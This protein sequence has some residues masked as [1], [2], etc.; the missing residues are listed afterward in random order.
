MASASCN[1]SSFIIGKKPGQPWHLPSLD[2]ATIESLHLINHPCTWQHNSACSW[3]Q[4]PYLDFPPKPVPE[5]KCITFLPTWWRLGYLGLHR[6]G[7]PLASEV[8]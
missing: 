6:C 1:E 2:Q 7:Q 5:R 3:Q 8:G 4:V